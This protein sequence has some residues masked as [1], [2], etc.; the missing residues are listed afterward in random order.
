MLGIV[1]LI[2]AG[3]LLLGGL[4]IVGMRNESGVDPLERRLA[5]YGDRE[6]PASLEELELSLSLQERVI[7]PMYKALAGF[8]VRF[9]PEN[10]I[11]SIRHQLELAGKSQSVEPTT[12]FGQRIA[13]T[14]GFGVGAFALFFLVSDWG[15]TKGILGTIG[16]ALLG[17]YLPVLQLRSQIRR[18]QDGIIKALP[19]AL[20]LLCICVEAG[21][22]FEQAMGKV[23][24]KWD[25]DLAIAFG[26]VLQEIQLGKRRSEALRDMSNRMEVNDVTSFIAA[27]IQAEQLGVSIAKILR[28]QADQM[29]VKRRQ[30]AQEKA[31]QAPVKMVIPMVLLIF[32]SLYIVLLG[33]A[34]II[35]LES[36]VFGAI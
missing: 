34:I 12:F 13:L 18:R 6:M 36:G 28:I 22:G 25:N 1:A 23:Y 4:V 30:R 2:V 3:I 7:I 14:I 11:D 35:L 19:N 32:P 24:E 26:R 33:P 16:A 10:Q 17:Y 20:D 9:T 8:V 21:L 31:Q 15:A 5:E 27:L 29:R